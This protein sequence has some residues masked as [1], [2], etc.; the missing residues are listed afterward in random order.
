MTKYLLTAC[1][2]LSLISAGQAAAKQQAIPD[3][4]VISVV[5]RSPDVKPYVISLP[6]EGRRRADAP[7][8]KIAKAKQVKAADT[9]AGAPPQLA[10]AVIK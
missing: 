8:D 7:E 4:D 3:V 6:A 9:G 1:A 10:S 2:A 5:P